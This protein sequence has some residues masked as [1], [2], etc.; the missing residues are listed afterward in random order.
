MY[1]NTKNKKRIIIKWKAIIWLFIVSIC[2]IDWNIYKAFVN[3]QFVEID[4]ILS[5]LT[6]KYHLKLLKKTI[7]KY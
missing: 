3:T 5:L 7:A 1:I 2:F 4:Y 6:N